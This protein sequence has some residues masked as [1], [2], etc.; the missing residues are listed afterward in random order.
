[1]KLSLSGL[2]WEVKGYWPYVPI[3]EKS[4]ETGQTLHGV[5]DF[6]PA[7]VPGGVHYDLWKAGLIRNPYFGLGSLECEWVENR[8]WLYRTS[9]PGILEGKNLQKE[10]VSLTFHG[11]DYEAEV[12]F[13]DVSIGTHKGMYDALTLNLTG[14]IREENKLVIVCKGIP[15]EMGQIGYT[16]RT[17]TQKSRF[18]YKWDFSTRLV[19]IGLWQDVT[20]EVREGAAIRELCV[21]TDYRQEKGIVSIQAQVSDHRKKMSA[22]SPAVPL[23]CRIILEGPGEYTSTDILMLRDL[24]NGKGE[25]CLEDFTKTVEDSR[26]ETAFDLPESG[27][28]QHELQIDNPKLWYPNGA[29]KQPLYKLVIELYTE[30][31]QKE[32]LLAR[33]EKKI[34][35]R[36]FSLL[37]NEEAPEEALP[38]TFCLNG[39]K[40][41]VRG[42]NMTPLDHIYGNVTKEQYAHMVAAMANAG[43][44]L[45]RVW[46]GGLIEK[47]EF[48]DLCDENGILIWQEF[49]Q[50]SSG[51]DN[52]PCEEEGYLSLLKTAAEYAV[53]QKRN[54]VSLIVYSGGNELMERENSP[55][56]LENKNISMLHDVVRRLDPGRAFLPTSASGPREFVSREKGVSHDVHGSWRYEGNP[57][58]YELYGESDHLFHSEFGMDGTSSVKSLRKFLPGEALHPTL[59]SEN[60]YW[61]H[62]GEWWGTYPRDCGMFGAIPREKGRLSYFTRCSQYM[63]SEGLRFIIEAD[64]R[65]AYKSSGVI[66]WQINEPWPNSSCTNLVDYYGETKTAY[67]HVKRTFQNRHIS[68][69]YRDLVLTPGEKMT[70]PVWIS[71]ADASFEA[72]A[73]VLLR[74]RKGEIL[75]KITIKG[76]AEENKSTLLGEITFEVPKEELVFLTAILK[77]NNRITDKNT[78]VFGTRRENVYGPLISQGGEAQIEKTEVIPLANGRYLGRV[79]LINP[80]D[81]VAADAGVELKGNGFY[82][83]GSDNDLALFPGERAE[84]T[85][86]MIPK[87]A[88]TFLDEE[89]WD[90]EEIPEFVKK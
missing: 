17:A 30:E 44:N 2:K 76:D 33:E 81:T 16:S 50:S 82:L 18:N 64:R 62:H 22:N 37:P 77:E 19:N 49:I 70:F 35:I 9:F 69:D 39:K 65:R 14:K 27:I 38:Y 71:N 6:I 41:F 86:L 55:C 43:V 32:I 57:G 79:T 5:T 52:K 42:V 45:V 48:Y 53:K 36:S 74:N 89:N 12:F 10:E 60:P 63:Q 56:G 80:S 90:G 29:G 3:K 83:L 73:E 75:K 59:M 85:F 87:Q 46:G 84:L 7:R 61:K 31:Q 47:E 20:L 23:R 11:I 54:H 66:I 8:W 68:L 51:I 67:Y 21:T 25:V 26:M 28:L 13:N 4:M 24:E 78:Y 72:E 34:G 15:Q 88:G 1:M 40:L 58:H